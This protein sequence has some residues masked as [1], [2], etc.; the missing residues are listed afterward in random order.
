[1]G[2]LTPPTEVN[3][4]DILLEDG[5]ELV[6]PVTEGHNAFV[7]PIH[8]TVTV[9]GQRFGND[10]PGLPVFPA[11]AE[12]RTVTLQARQGSAKAVLF[13]GLPLRQPVHWQGSMALSSPEA[14]AAAVARYQRGEFGTLS[15]R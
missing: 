11:Q 14:L 2:P 10:G 7:M 3:L 4:L 8:G 1:M 13:A 12:P 5:A 9:D 6:V 15:S